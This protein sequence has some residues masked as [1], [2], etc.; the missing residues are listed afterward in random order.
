M[1]V[2]NVIKKIMKETNTRKSNIAHSEN[3]SLQLIN[4]RFNRKDM[5]TATTVQMLRG[6]GYKLVAMPK[7]DALPK[8]A[9]EIT[10]EE[11]KK[12]S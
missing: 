12:G 7:G 3:V 10:G 2:I 4:S 11:E 8:N 6:C 1:N 5:T 9:Y